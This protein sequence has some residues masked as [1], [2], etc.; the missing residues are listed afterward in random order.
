MYGPFKLISV[1][2]IWILAGFLGGTWQTELKIYM[3]IQKTKNGQEEEHLN[4]WR[5][6]KTSEKTHFTRYQTYNKSVTTDCKDSIVLV[7]V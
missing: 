6:T 7:Q 5:R 1:V 4:T 3:K 2:L